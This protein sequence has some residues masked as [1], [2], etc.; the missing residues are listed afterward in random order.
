MSVQTTPGR[1]TPTVSARLYST[2]LVQ[3]MDI[4]RKYRLPKVCYV[5][6]TSTA[7]SKDF[8]AAAI[9]GIGREVNT[10]L[11][12]AFGEGHLG[13][14]YLMHLMKRQV[15]YMAFRPNDVASFFNSFIFGYRCQRREFFF[16]H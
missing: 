6:A 9:N 15:D 14:V 3:T 2:G 13:W 12:E 16:R 4:K 8:L 10:R 11:G 1:R 5:L 7:S